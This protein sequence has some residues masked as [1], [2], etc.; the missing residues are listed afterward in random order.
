MKRI[1][2]FVAIY[3]CY[4]FLFLTVANAAEPSLHLH[5]SW[6]RE[7]PPSAK[8]L[9]AFLS[10]MNSGQSDRVLMSVEADSFEKVEIHKMEVHGKMTHMVLQKELLIPAGETV[11]LEPGGY[12]LMMM[13]PD[14]RF[15]AGDN[16]T[17]KFKFKDGEII[18][19]KA[20]V[21]K[22]NVDMDG[23]DHGE[24]AGH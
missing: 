14:K 23:H 3:A 18:V 11:L 10:I 12:H 1:A 20:L 2:G 19:Q 4:V 21:R 7:A 15:R 8:V 13:R 6:V 17:L 16:V 9:G 24:H 5:D 22:S